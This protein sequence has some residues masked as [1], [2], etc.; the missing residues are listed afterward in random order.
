[1]KLQRKKNRTRNLEIWARAERGATRRC[2]SDWG[3]NLW[4]WNSASSKSWGQE[5]CQ[6]MVDVAQQL[7]SRIFPEKDGGIQ[8]RKDMWSTAISPASGELG[9]TNNTALQLHSNPPNPIY[10]KTRVDLLAW[11]ADSLQANELIIKIGSSAGFRNVL[12]T[13]CNAL[14]VRA[15]VGSGTITAI[16]YYY[17]Y[18]TYTVVP[19]RIFTI[20]I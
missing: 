5:T 17:Y 15:R 12:Y 2:K 16:Y 14:P 9:A 18:T 11:Q 10:R 3:D 13:F 8:N 4:R 6:I 20:M 1:M 7:L 19:W